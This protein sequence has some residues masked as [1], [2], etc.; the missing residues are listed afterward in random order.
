MENNLFKYGM[1]FLRVC[2][3]NGKPVTISA[4]IITLGLILSCADTHG[5]RAAQTGALDDGTARKSDVLETTVWAVP[6]EQKVRP[7][8]RVE[9]SNL[10]WSARDKK[11]NV[12]GAGNEHVPFQVVIT[13]PVSGSPRQVQAPDGFFIE[14]SDFVS[15]GGNR[16]SLENVSFYLQHYILLYAKS[17]PVGATGYWPDALAPI[18]V[19]FSMSAHYHVVQNRP[20]WVDLYLPSGT[21]GGKYTGTITVTRHGHPLET[22]EVEV[23]VYNFSLPDETSLITYINF[24]RERLATFY[25]KPVESDEMDELA[26]K[27]FEKLYANRMDPSR[28]ELLNPEIEVKGDE[29]KLRFDHDNYLYYLNE[30]KIKRVLMHT[31]PGRL[32]GQITAEP[33]SEEFT[34]IVQSYLKQVEAYYKANGWEDRLVFSSPVDEPRS[35]EEYENTRRWATLARE[36][37]PDVPFLVTRTPVPVRSNPEWGSFHGYADNFS[38]HGNHMNNTE[39]PGVIEKERARGGELTW[40]ISCDQR[41]PQPNYFIDGPAMD[42]VMVPWI[43]AR[44]DMDG[45]LYWAVNFWSQTPNPWLDA[46]TFHSGFLCSGGWVLNGEGSL[47]YPG[48]FT[49]QF[50]GQ[51]N[52][53]GPVSSIR[54]ELLREG[55]EDYVYLSM[56]KEL[57]DREFARE[58]VKNIVV[59][60]SSFSRN[61]EKLYNTRRMMARRIEELTR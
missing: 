33:F 19:P 3:L 47:L 59:D 31:Y 30:L 5:Q 2:Y 56:L 60:V 41:Y 26:R 15:S 51:P 8:D 40:Y 13:T 18:I 43:T 37:T 1:Y 48:D 24:S 11:I 38:I 28:N 45:I 50:T 54:F 44:Y 20:L 42:P 16:I 53:D 22:L 46:S 61:V 21:P 32:R 52:V 49:E 12:A 29:V 10:I 6:A 9:S 14:A 7:E 36:A 27:Y 4:F 58:L 34:R 55:I 17:S 23:E 25:N 39:L 35:L 57:G